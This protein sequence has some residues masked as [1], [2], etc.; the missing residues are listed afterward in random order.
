MHFI[1]SSIEE[2]QKKGQL[3]GVILTGLEARAVDIFAQYVNLTGDVQT[4]ALALSHIIPKKF[5]DAR[6]EQ[7]VKRYVLFLILFYSILFYDPLISSFGSYRYFLDVWQLWHARAKFD[8]ARKDSI[9]PQI[10]V[11]CNFCNQGL[12]MSLI[13]SRRAAATRT[14]RAA[15]TN[16]G[17]N[18]N[19]QKQTVS[20]RNRQ[21]IG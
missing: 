1:E 19:T 14:G 16:Q 2:H 10:Y 18:V 15:V 9:P 3:E 6:V 13:T 11:R 4:A 7:W 21:S 17:Y 12:T 5:K 8:I 20:N